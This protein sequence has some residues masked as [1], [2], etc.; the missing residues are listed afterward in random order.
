M[1]RRPP[2]S[3][4]FPYTTLFRSFGRRLHRR[5]DRGRAGASLRLVRLR[6]YRDDGETLAEQCFERGDGEL[7]R[8]EKEHAPP[9]L[10][11]RPRRPVF[12]VPGL[13]PARLLPLGEEQSPLHRAP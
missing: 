2:R 1:I 7:R 6:D 8:S 13:P 12:H 11:P 10:T 3:T 9:E 4:L 5:R